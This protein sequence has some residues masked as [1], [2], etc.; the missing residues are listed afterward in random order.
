MY[1]FSRESLRSVDQSA[2]YSPFSTAEFE[3]TPVNVAT[4]AEA[5]AHREVGEM[6]ALATFERLVPDSRPAMAHALLQIEIELL[7]R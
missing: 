6:G 3:R 2:R 1:S 4:D 7:E 5:A